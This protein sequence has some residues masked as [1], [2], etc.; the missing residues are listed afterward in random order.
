[1]TIIFTVVPAAMPSSCWPGTWHSMSLLLAT[2]GAQVMHC[3]S[4]GFGTIGATL[5]VTMPTT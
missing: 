2:S 3:A 1:M 5:Q 4:R